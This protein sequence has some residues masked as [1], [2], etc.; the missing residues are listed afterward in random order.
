MTVSQALTRARDAEQDTA[1]ASQ[2]HEM[3]LGIQSE[4]F[5]Y[6]HV[7]ILLTKDSAAHA[8]LRVRSAREMLSLLRGMVSNWVQVYNG[9]VW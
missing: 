6:L 1:D 4:K 5:Q 3:S 9:M 7:L 2:L 8:D